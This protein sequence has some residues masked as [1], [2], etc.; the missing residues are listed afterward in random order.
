NLQEYLRSSNPTNDNRSPSL[1]TADMFVYSAGATGIRLQSLDSDTSPTNLSYT[2]L[3]V[4][5]SGTLYL[6]NANP[7]PASSD[8]ALTSGSTFTQG[9]IDNGRLMFVHQ[10]ADSFT[11]ADS[12]TISL[13]DENPAHFAT[14]NEVALNIYLPNYSD[15]TLQKAQAVPA[16]PGGFSDIGG[17][18][19]YEQ[20]MLLNYFLSR[21]HGY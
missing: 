4:P 16:A 1:V 11:T 8:A 2:L 13:R 21:D 5:Q 17:L 10:S 3:A 7:N 18:S 9:D 19:F 6:R 12:F 15:A 20:Q 14:T